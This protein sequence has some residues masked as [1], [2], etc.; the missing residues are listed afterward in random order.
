MLREAK[1]FVRRNSW[2]DRLKI[3]LA[4]GKND[5]GVSEASHHPGRYQ[6]C[7]RSCALKRMIRSG[8]VSI[9]RERE[10]EDDFLV[11]RL[12]AADAAFTL[13][14]DGLK[15]PGIA[16]FRAVSP[17]NGS[18]VLLLFILFHRFHPGLPSS[19]LRSHSYG[20]IIAE[21]IVV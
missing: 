13:H 9:A 1:R 4:A 2:W 18:C 20:K 7:T 14:D 11:F 17:Y 3:E 5:R 10:S 8:E 16:A 15:R 21:R 12:S 6:R 19:Q